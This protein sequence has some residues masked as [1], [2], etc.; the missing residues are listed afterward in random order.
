LHISC[1]FFA[2][3]AGVEAAESCAAEFAIVAEH[4][5]PGSSWVE[6]ADIAYSLVAGAEVA[7]PYSAEFAIVA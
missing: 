7:K 2:A 3:V 1:P 4:R 6:A 5:A